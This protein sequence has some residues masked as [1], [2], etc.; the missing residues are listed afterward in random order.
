MIIKGCSIRPLRDSSRATRMM[1]RSLPSSKARQSIFDLAEETAESSSASSSVDALI[2]FRRMFKVSYGHARC[3]VPAEVASKYS[4]AE[5]NSQLVVS[6]TNRFEGH[7]SWFNGERSRKPQ[8]FIQK[9][10]QDARASDTTGDGVRCDFC[11]WETMT[12]VESFGRIE[13]KHAVSGSN[14]F[15]YGEPY[16]GL[17]LFKHHNPL[18]FDLEQLQDLTSV[19]SE[20]F[21][22]ARRENQT[23][24]GGGGGGAS[25]A[26][27]IWNCLSRAGAS[28]YHGHAQLLLTREP[29]P[30]HTRMTEASESYR[31]LYPGQS[32][33]R[34]LMRALEEAELAASIP[35]SRTGSTTGGLNS[36]SNLSWIAAS[37]CPIK[38]M[39]M[40]ITG[41]SIEDPNFVL[42]LFIALRTL[43]DD[44]GI[45]SFN[46]GV[47]ECPDEEGGVLARVVSRGKISQTA[48]DFGALEVIGGASIGHTD[49]YHLLGVIK[50]RLC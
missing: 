19:S 31:S 16:H 3:M 15:K 48:S 17:V 28:Q 27:F 38:D 4:V 8:T 30:I 46:V 24:Q 14:L 32:Y 40:I 23:E 9:H 41:T 49:P 36:C 34:D 20:W 5:D 44:F 1:S 33:T 50:R 6:V 22:R 26:F 29:L 2:L 37:P 18:S 11:K 39:E 13:R 25:H 10:G 45:E 12:A 7:M 35:I 47:V 42:A 43:I 21:H